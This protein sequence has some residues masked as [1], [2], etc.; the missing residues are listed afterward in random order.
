MSSYMPTAESIDRKWYIIDAEGK[1]LGRVAAAAA[2]L[3][4]GKQKP[5]FVPHIDCGD[6]VIIINAE[7]AVLT[8]KK[9]EEKMYRHHS[10]WVGHMKEIQYGTLMKQ[11]PEKAMELAVKGMVPAT[12]IGRNALTRLHVYRGA[13][14]DNAAQKPVEY[15]I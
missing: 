1:P 10:L 12:V 14:H 3:L 8:G 11:K 5:I 4:R 2:V 15:K 6:N 7:K 9:L 13:E